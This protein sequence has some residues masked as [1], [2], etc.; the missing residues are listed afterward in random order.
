MSVI[1][2]YYELCLVMEKCGYTFLQ[3]MILDEAVNYLAEIQI[4]MFFP[5]ARL[6]ANAIA[7][8]PQSVNPTC[9]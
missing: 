3:S 5:K 6:V 4:W 8:S 9:F 1:Y 2:N 7:K